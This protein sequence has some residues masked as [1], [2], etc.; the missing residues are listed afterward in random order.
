MMLDVKVLGLDGVEVFCDV[1]DV[2]LVIETESRVT[3]NY[4]GVG[5]ANHRYDIRTGTHIF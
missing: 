1:C 5:R 4:I 3:S 2:F